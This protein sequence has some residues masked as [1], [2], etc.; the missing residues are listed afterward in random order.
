M[1]VGA[2]GVPDELTVI[3]AASVG[4]VSPI[5]RVVFDGVVT[6]VAPHD[7]SGPVTKSLSCE[8]GWFDV[9]VSARKLE[10]HSPP[11]LR[12]AR[13]MP[14]SKKWPTGKASNPPIFATGTF[15]VNGHG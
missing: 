10:K 4:A 2:G 8:P 9:R 12:A 7:A 1:A 15:A 11:R 5:V 6:S 3:L 13:S 14:P